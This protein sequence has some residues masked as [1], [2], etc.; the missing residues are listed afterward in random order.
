MVANGR[1]ETI[2]IVVL[3][4]KDT[5]EQEELDV[6]FVEEITVDSGAVF[7]QQESERGRRA[8]TCWRMSHDVRRK[9]CVRFS[10]QAQPI[11]SLTTSV[12]LDRTPPYAEDIR[13]SD[14]RSEENRM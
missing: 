10:W 8:C 7:G 9:V 5:R 4:A 13:V 11:S 2:D 14:G 3:E 6:N 12:P 1:D